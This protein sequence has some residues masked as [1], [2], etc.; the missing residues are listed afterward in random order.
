MQR[1]GEDKLSG[2]AE[3]KNRNLTADDKKRPEMDGGWK[4]RRKKAD[5]G[6]GT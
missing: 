6:N 1:R 5:K 4:E 3:Q 2:E